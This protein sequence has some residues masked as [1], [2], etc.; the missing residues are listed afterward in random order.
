MDKVVMDATDRDLGEERADPEER[1]VSS[2]NSPLTR[3]F[4]RRWLKVIAR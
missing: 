4:R 2:V 1:C 3:T